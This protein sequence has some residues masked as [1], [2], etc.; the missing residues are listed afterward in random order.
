MRTSSESASEQEAGLGLLGFGSAGRPD[1]PER[2][3]RTVRAKVGFKDIVPRATRLSG[4]TG[5]T[6]R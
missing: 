4:N 2:L 1:G 6:Q 5:K 3:G